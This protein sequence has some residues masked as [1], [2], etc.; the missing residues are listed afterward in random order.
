MSTRRRRRAE[1]PSSSAAVVETAKGGKETWFWEAGG[2]LV[3]TRPVT[4]EPMS[5]RK[6]EEAEDEEWIISNDDAL[7]LI[8]SSRPLPL[9]CPNFPQGGSREEISE[10]NKACHRVYKLTANDPVTHPPL[11]REI[12]DDF[13]T[14]SST[15][16]FYYPSVSRHREMIVGLERSIV[17]I[18]STKNDG[19]PKWKFNG[20]IIGPSESDERARILTSSATVCNYKGKLDRKVIKDGELLFFDDH[21][22]LAIL[23]IS[24]DMPFRCPAFVSSPDYG[25]DVFVLTRKEDSSLM[26]TA[27]KVLWHN[28][29]F[30]G[31]NH[32]LYLSCEERISG[33]LVMDRDGY[34]AGMTFDCPNPKTGVLPGFIIKK[35]IEMASNFR[36]MARPKHGLSLRAVQFLDMSR[37]EE[38]LYKHKI[39]SGYLVDEVEI[40]STAEFIGIRHGDVIVSVNGICSLNLLELE[41]YFVSL[42]WKF[43]EKKI[44]LSKIVL[45]L[46]VYDPLN[47]QENI[48]CLPL[49]FACL[50]ADPVT[51]PPLLRETKDDFDTSSSSTGDVLYSASS[52]HREMV[53]GLA[54]SIVSIS[55]TENDGLPEWNF[56]GIWSI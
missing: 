33:G 2:R 50:P 42:G 48:L 30:L 32:Y 11:L 24:V 29:P 38:I 20:I 14:S 40:N 12:K 8:P 55:S 22:G 7:P 53:V 46:K 18:S 1:E 26:T 52:R 19:L 31:R 27:G 56:N 17:S 4:A 51:H 43:L 36:C 15:S 10:W 45:K 39:Y 3:E 34:I 54:R 44:E 28:E 9:R 25:D 13:D 6:A 47:C 49:G 23:E 41:E 35:L 21:Y 16:D 37:R 5:G